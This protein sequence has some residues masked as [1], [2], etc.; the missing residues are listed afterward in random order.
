[1]AEQNKENPKFDFKSLGLGQ[2]VKIKLDGAKPAKSAE[3][4]Y[5]IWN[6]WFGY[7]ENETVTRGRKPNEVKEK[8]FTG[9]VIFFPTEKLNE[10]IMDATNGKTN[11]E[12]EVTKTAEETSQGTII[13]KYLLAKLSDG[14]VASAPEERKELLS[15]EMTL[16][17]DALELKKDGYKVTEDIFLKSSKEPQYGGEISEERAKELF[18]QFNQM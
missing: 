15:S 18:V 12:V 16:I 3:G 14:E 1:M 10:K 2:S 8:E 9:K 7:V 6:M 13:K 5:G 4:E 17:N 11:V